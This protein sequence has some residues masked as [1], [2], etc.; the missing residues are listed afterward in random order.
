MKT[1][2]AAMVIAISVGFS[3]QAKTIRSTELKGNLWAKTMSDVEC[4][5]QW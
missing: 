1:T 2:I 3:A 4:D 5:L